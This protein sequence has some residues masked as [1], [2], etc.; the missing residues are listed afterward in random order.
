MP[1]LFVVAH[2]YNNMYI[3][4][5]TNGLPNTG[6]LQFQDGGRL[7]RVSERVPNWIDGNHHTVEAEW[8]PV[9]QAIRLAIDGVAVTPTAVSAS[10]LRGLVREDGLAVVGLTAASG[11]S[12][13]VVHIHSWHVIPHGTF[14]T[15]GVRAVADNTSGASRPCGGWVL[16]GTLQDSNNGVGCSLQ[17]DMETEASY[18]TDQ[19]HKHLILGPGEGLRMSERACR[20]S[21]AAAAAGAVWTAD[22]VVRW[23]QAGSG[24]TVLLTFPTVSLVLTT[25]GTPE[26]G[27]CA[28]SQLQPVPESE[29]VTLRVELDAHALRLLANGVDV[30]YFSSSCSQVPSLDSLRGHDLGESPTAMMHSCHCACDRHVHQHRAHCVGP[31]DRE[32]CVADS[33]PSCQRRYCAAG[34]CQLCASVDRRQHDYAA[35]SYGASWHSWDLDIRFLFLASP[36]LFSLT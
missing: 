14:A 2:T 28:G 12:A 33:R 17:Y 6:G 4:V 15:I 21:D 30:G 32:C 5:A 31:H 11:A 16:D 20:F 22:F 3:E 26:L 27:T 23:F 36:G 29:W 1:N 18:G 25:A 13:H 19:G 24:S 9:S 7:S 34:F 35:N 8:N 10:V